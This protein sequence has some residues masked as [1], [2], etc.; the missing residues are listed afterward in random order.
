MPGFPGAKGRQNT[1]HQ[2]MRLSGTKILRFCFKIKVLPAK[3][4]FV[5][6]ME[7]TERGVI[8]AIR[9]QWDPLARRVVVDR[10]GSQVYPDLEVRMVVK[11]LRDPW[12]QK[13][14]EDPKENVVTLAHQV[15][16]VVQSL[17]SWVLAVSPE[18]RVARVNLEH[19]VF[20]D[21]L[22]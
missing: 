7:R 19:L 1:Y 18:K 14:N 4:V 17:V 13:V 22:V 12:V 15:Q 21:H 20:K 11:V 2:L 9:V 8:Q 16:T 10:R 3:R 5:E 6:Q